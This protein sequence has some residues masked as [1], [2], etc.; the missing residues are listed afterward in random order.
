LG[1]EEFRD[2][3]VLRQLVDLL[4]RPDLLNSPRVHHGDPLPDHQRLDLVVRHVH[5]RPS[6]IA[7]QPHQLG[8]HPHPQAGIQ[9]AERFIQQQ[10]VRVT[11]QRSSDRDPL[12]L[13]ARQLGRLPLQQVLDAQQFRDL[14]HAALRLLTRGTPHLTSECQVAANASV[15]I[16]GQVLEDHRDLSVLGRQVFD[17]TRSDTNPT[18]V[19]RLESRNHSQGG[20]L[21]AARRS[22][23]DQQFLI[24]DHQ[25]DLV[26][27]RLTSEAL[28]HL[29]QKQFGHC[30]TGSRS[31]DKNRDHAADQARDR[32]QHE[33]QEAAAADGD[34][35]V[36]GHRVDRL[37]G[38]R[39]TGPGFLAK[40]LGGMVDAALTQQHQH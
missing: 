12:L 25:I 18:A 22:D 15:G 19:G 4:R 29:F 38:F 34:P 28:R 26:H 14:V 10:H 24:R 31:E 35:V 8:P 9:I 37:A 33:R 3:A 21:A 17:V 30:G 6:Q 2:K 13:A 39:G 40:D 27:C 11:D 16:Q 20:R 36:T 23:Q 1:A 5:N 32:E 7:L